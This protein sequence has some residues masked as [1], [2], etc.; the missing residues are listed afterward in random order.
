MLMVSILFLSIILILY[1]LARLFC[2]KTNKLRKFVDDKIQMIFWNGVFRF[3]LEAFLNILIASLLA[4]ETSKHTLFQGTIHKTIS[5]IAAII[6]LLYIIIIPIHIFHIIKSKGDDI[7]LERQL[8]H[9]DVMSY[10]HKSID[11]ESAKKRYPLY[12]KYGI[13]VE[14]QKFK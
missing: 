3:Y 1:L 9:D 7:R 14:G 13:V 12:H 2:D 6:N 4:I 11:N 10:K 5:D 8:W